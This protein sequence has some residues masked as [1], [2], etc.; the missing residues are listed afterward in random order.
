L[1]KKLLSGGGTTRHWPSVAAVIENV[2]SRPVFKV[3]KT[4]ALRLILERLEIHLRTK[5]TEDTEIPA[6]LQIE[7]VLPQKWAARWLLRERLVPANVAE[8]PYLAKDDL[9]EFGEPIRLRNTSLQTLGNLTLLNQ[10]LNPAAGNG[11]FEDKLI[12]YKDSVLRLNRYF[13]SK[14]AWNEEAIVQ[15]GRLLGEALCKIWPRPDT[16][17]WPDIEIRDAAEHQAGGSTAI[18]VTELERPNDTPPTRP[19]PG[20]ARLPPEGTKCRFTYFS[21]EYS[22]TIAEGR[23]QIEGM[24]DAYGSFS[25]ASSAVTNTAR[26]GWMDWQILLPGSDDWLSADTWRNS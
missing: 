26:N 3:I 7:H 12:E 18:E 24:S 5:K 20:N 19:H 17:Q 1:Q 8:Y 11:S 15:R 25:A 2:I 21:K 16:S 10:Y 14:T 13:D 9:A 23:I 4:P 22:G 6:G